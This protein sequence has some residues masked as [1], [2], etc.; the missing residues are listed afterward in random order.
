MTIKAVDGIAHKHA[1]RVGRREFLRGA[2]YFLGFGAL[3]AGFG[4]ATKQMSD[5]SEV[6]ACRMKA[7]L[8]LGEFLIQG[9]LKLSPSEI[10]ALPIGKIADMLRQHGALP[11]EPET[12]L[13]LEILGY[14][15]G[16]A[17]GGLAIKTLVDTSSGKAR[18]TNVTLNR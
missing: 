17:V 8:S 9:G 13:P 11:H 16:S 7:G 14:G 6:Q 5:N 15:A 10:Y 3:G 4:S 12:P 18:D 2:K 1:D